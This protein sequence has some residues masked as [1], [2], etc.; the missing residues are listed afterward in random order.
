MYVNNTLCLFNGQTRKYEVQVD[1]RKNTAVTISYENTLYYPTANL[2]GDGEQ[3]DVNLSTGGSGKT[4]AKGTYSFIID[5]TAKTLSYKNL[6]PPGESTLSPTISDNMLDC[7]AEDYSPEE[8]NSLWYIDDISSMGWLHT[9][10]DQDSHDIHLGNGH[11]GVSMLGVVGEKIM[12]NEKTY[13]EGSRPTDYSAATAIGEYKR[14]G[15]LCTYMS[16]S[17]AQTY[18]FIEQLDMMKGVGTT[19][20]TPTLYSGG[21]P[22]IYKEYLVSRPDDVFA[23]YITSGEQTFNIELAFDEL[24]FISRDVDSG[25]FSARGDLTTVSTCFA[26]RAIPDGGASI[27]TYNDNGIKVTGARQL[28]ILVSSKSNYDIT[29]ESYIDESVKIESAAKAIVDAAA[30]RSW[31]EL[32]DRHVADHSAL[33]QACTIDLDISNDTPTNELLSLYK[34]GNAS[35]IRKRT[36]EQLLFQYGRYKTIGSSRKGDQLPNNLRGIWMSAQRWNGDIHSDL[37]IEMNYWP[38]ENTNLSSCHEPFLDYIITMSGK[39]EWKGYAQYRAPGADSNAWTL[40]NANNIFGA[41]QSYI[42][43]YSESNAWFCYHLW[44]HWL[45]TL[46]RQFLTRAVPVMMNACKFWEK[47]MTWDSSL[48]KWICP[49]VWSPENGSGGNTAVH[50]RQMVRELFKNTITGIETLGSDFAEGQAHLAELKSIF[51]DIDPG[52]HIVN[53]ALCEWYGIAPSDDGH[54]HLSHLMCLYPMAQVSPYDSDLTTFN[55]AVNALDLRGDGDGGEAAV[56]NNAWKMGCRAR[57]LD[58]GEWGAYHQLGK[59]IGF[60]FDNLNAS[61]ANVHQ[62]DGNSGMTAGIAEM[63]LQSYSGVIDILP[64]LPDE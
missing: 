32:Y 35:D 10:A 27:T 53:G 21:Q 9:G 58:N 54:R 20:I 49:E 16:I 3:Y 38:A 51:N 22:N 1:L 25:Y 29:R 26:C 6:T 33:M 57:A 24:T 30:S 13:F 5:I 12:L 60:L 34:N 2:T 52:L 15:Y 62:I 50:A 41:A 56:W 46:D 23:L 48:N 63:L 11:L 40:D 31:Q 17:D 55:A 18:N 36:L 44:Q 19:R 42:S 8:Q 7:T 59:G 28:L 4:D 43:T 45:Y 39:T 14:A 47:K 64:V 37:N 61:T